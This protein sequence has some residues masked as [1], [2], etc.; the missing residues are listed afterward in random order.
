MRKIDRIS[1]YTMKTRDLEMGQKSKI[2]ALEIL[3]WDHR[4][5]MSIHTFKTHHCAAFVSWPRAAQFSNLKPKS[6]TQTAHLS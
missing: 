3:K 2:I 5:L 1:K 6:I 4:D